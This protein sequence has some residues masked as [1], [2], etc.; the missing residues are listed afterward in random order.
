MTAP[1]AACL[2]VPEPYTIDREMP[3]VPFGVLIAT[4]GIGW[5]L[6]GAQRWQRIAAVSAL[7]LGV[8]HFAFLSR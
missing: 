1:V 7:V 5:L 2:V 4:A 3:V 8:A 6:S